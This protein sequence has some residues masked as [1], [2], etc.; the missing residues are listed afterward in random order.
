MDGECTVSP[1][2]GSEDACLLEGLGAYPVRA[3]CGCLVD[4]P[5]WGPVPLLVF[6]IYSKKAIK[7]TIIIEIRLFSELNAGSGLPMTVLSVRPGG[8]QTAG[9]LK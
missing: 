5:F 4:G 1:G 8:A 9:A 6:K 7:S 2:L 3:F